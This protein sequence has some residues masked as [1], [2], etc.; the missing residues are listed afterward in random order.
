MRDVL[1][2]NDGGVK[3]CG[4]NWLCTLTYVSQMIQH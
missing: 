2:K 4:K 1:Q 3:S